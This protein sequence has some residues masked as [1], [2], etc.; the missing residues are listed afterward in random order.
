MALILAMLFVAWLTWIGV[1]AARRVE[2]E[3]H[4]GELLIFPPDIPCFYCKGPTS[5]ASE[6]VLRCINSL[7][8]NNFPGMKSDLDLGAIVF[9]CLQCGGWTI[10]VHDA[11]DGRWIFFCSRCGFEVDF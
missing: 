3:K 10:R 6:S 5:W 2:R 1:R 4:A 7:C 11:N 8:R 9:Y